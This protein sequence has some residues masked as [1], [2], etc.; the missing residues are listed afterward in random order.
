MVVMTRREP[1]LERPRLPVGEA[2]VFVDLASG[3][4]ITTGLRCSLVQRGGGRLLGRSVVTPSG[5]HVWPDLAERW[6]RPAEGV[7]ADVLVRDELQR[8]QPLSLPW[9]L[10][11]RP[12]GQILGERVL[13]GM[14]MMRIGLLSAPTRRPPAG[15]CSVYG[16]LTWQD[17]GEPASWARVCLTDAEG[18]VHQGASDA[19]GRLALHLSPPRPG[20]VGAAAMQVF[21]DPAL[22]AACMGLGAPDVLAFAG[23]PAV[24]ALADVAGQAAFVPGAMAAHEPLILATHGLP[25]AHREL[26]L[27][28]A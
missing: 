26:R 5:L 14:R 23:Q 27:A 19:E 11:A 16:L 15:V 4:L 28:R 3:D 13:G 8:F 6:R 24:L 17:D 7:C 20:S 2:L 1:T 22:G 9:P 21:A 25:P 12:V 10:P 18:R